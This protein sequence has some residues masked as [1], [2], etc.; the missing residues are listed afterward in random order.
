M[1]PTAAHKGEDNVQMKK[2]ARIFQGQGATTGT[3][4]KDG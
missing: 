1:V 4:E 3:R 2:S